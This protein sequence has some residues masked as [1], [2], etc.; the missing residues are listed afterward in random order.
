MKHIKISDTSPFIAPFDG[1]VLHSDSIN[2]TGENINVK[3]LIKKYKSSPLVDGIVFDGDWENRPLDFI[4]VLEAVKG[5]GLGVVINTKLTMDDFKL[6]VGIA[7]YN[8]V[9]NIRMQRKDV[10]ENDV[11]MLIFIGSI[12]IDFY[13]GY[14]EYYIRYKEKG[15]YRLCKIDLPKEE[16]ENGEETNE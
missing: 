7:S 13:L 5:S 6:T 2:G 16:I 15:E 9:N 8:K 4:K 11:P 10:S 14:T 12:L 3:K 1:V